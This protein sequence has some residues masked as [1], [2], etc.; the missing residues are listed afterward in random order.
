MRIVSGAIVCAV[1]LLVL[2]ARAAAQWS[3]TPHVGTAF[4]GSVPDA[5]RVDYGIAAGWMGRLVGF[6]VDFSRT[7]DFFDATDVPDVLFRESSVATLMV[8]GLIGVPL[9]GDR[10][11]P[12]AAGGIGW[13]RSRIGG[14][15]AFVRGRGDNVGFNVGGGVIASFS[16]LFG[17]RGDVRYF[18]DLQEIEGES[19]FF[20]VDK[21][22]FWRATVGAV[23]RF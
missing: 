6:E 5:P 7:P 15:D 17:V 23:F 3:V 12:Y 14:D 1:C 9:G 8:N 19:E 16:S 11:R 2:P 18:R 20:G 10:L 4:G 13:V 22:D 21:I